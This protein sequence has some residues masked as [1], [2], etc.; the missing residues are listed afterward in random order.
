MVRGR[1]EPVVRGQREA[2]DDQQAQADHDHLV[3]ELHGVEGA[4][5]P[6]AAQ[7][8]EAGHAD[9]HGSH[10][11]RRK[12]G[13]VAESTSEP[14]HRPLDGEQETSGRP[15]RGGVPH[16]HRQE[17]E[18]AGDGT[19]DHRQGAGRVLPERTGADDPGDGADP[20]GQTGDDTE[21]GREPRFQQPFA[22]PPP[23]EV[24]LPVVVQ[25]ASQEC[26]PPSGLF[27]GPATVPPGGREPGMWG[28]RGVDQVLGQMLLDGV[29]A[30]EP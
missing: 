2:N 16:D 24:A 10:G 8:D 27:G 19:G 12:H 5:T 6:A 14:A 28:V 15:P 29:L 23:G 30:V 1:V 22:H 21:S 18:A 26:Q 7:R 11:E 25:I 20:E 4:G 13:P 3:V 17:R 9:E